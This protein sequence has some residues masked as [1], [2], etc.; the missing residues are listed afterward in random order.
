M[1]GW[2]SLVLPMVRS[3]AL[4]LCPKVVA[5]LQIP[6]FALLAFLTIYCTIHIND[7]GSDYCCVLY[8]GSNKRDSKD[9]KIF[10]DSVMV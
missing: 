8:L 1:L 4:W 2:S 3:I 6:V 7:Q 5:L 9:I 10:F